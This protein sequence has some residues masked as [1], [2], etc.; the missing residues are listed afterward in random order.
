MLKV[1]LLMD[2]KRVNGMVLLKTPPDIHVFMKKEFQKKA[3][4]M[5]NMEIRIPSPLR[6]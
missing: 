2:L 4:V 6:I 3:R 5:I 1:I